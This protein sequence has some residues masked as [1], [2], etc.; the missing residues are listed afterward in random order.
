M[1]LAKIAENK[2]REAMAR[3]EFDTLVGAGQP[4]DLEEYFRTPEDL[5]MAYSVLKSAK[6]LPE[7]VEL[8]NEIAALDRELGETTSEDARARLRRRLR[9]RRLQLAM[10]LDRQ[11]TR[12]R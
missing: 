8:M 7:E 10:A 1:S 6:C 3:G 12:K 4:I 2:I 11:R 5:R 9:D